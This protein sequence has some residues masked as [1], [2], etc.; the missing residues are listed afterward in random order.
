MVFLYQILRFLTRWP[1]SVDKP[2][3]FCDG[4]IFRV[5]V[6]AVEFHRG[7]IQGTDALWGV[8]HTPATQNTWN[9]DTNNTKVILLQR[10]SKENDFL[11]IIN[12]EQ[13]QKNE[14][15][16]VK[17]LWTFLKCIFLFLLMTAE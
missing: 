1:W 15:Y 9:M 4:V 17:R 14:Y 11:D 13:I 7:A 2:E 8:R 12:Q 5:R 16:F 6:I 3:C 10:F